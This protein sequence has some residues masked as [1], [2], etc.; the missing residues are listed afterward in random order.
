MK[1]V[2]ILL[3]F[4][5][6]A[7]LSFGQYS[8]GSTPKPYSTQSRCYYNKNSWSDTS[9][10]NSTNA[11]AVSGGVLNV[12]S[13]HSDALF[14]YWCSLKDTFCSDHWVMAYRI[15]M[16][17]TVGAST[18]GFSIGVKSIN[19]FSLCSVAGFPNTATGGGQT[20]FFTD[21]NSAGWT[22]YWTA[23]VGSKITIST[24][25]KIIARLE[26]SNQTLRLT[27]YNA[28]TKAAQFDTTVTLSYQATGSTPIMP[29]T[30]VPTF[31]SHGGNITIDSIYFQDEA[32]SN[33][34]VAIIGDSKIWGYGAT[35]Y[36]NT[37]PALLRNY[38][39]SVDVFAGFG[40]RTAEVISRLAEV[41]AVHPRCVIMAIGSNDVRNSVPTATLDSNLVKIDTTL[42]NAGI[43]V[44]W[45][46][47]FYETSVSLATLSSFINS[48]FA[49]RVINTY[50]P[51]QQSGCLYSDNIHLTN[52]GY[53]VAAR[54]IEGSSLIPQFVSAYRPNSKIDVR[55]ILKSFY[56]KNKIICIPNIFKSVMG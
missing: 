42:T 18:Y 20:Q 2:F 23:G 3:L 16:T 54:C 44:L 46:D 47:E 48:R 51:T 36:S 38:Y 15:A 13:A 10:F 14:N 35:A 31:W 55:E 9:D 45:T 56:D 11:V 29:N 24:S 30:G 7:V 6:S 39:N 27:I 34:D 22:T 17:S 53:D 25:N 41:K 28:T 50:L 49:G 43:Y 37:I 4:L 1:K 33:A 12:T 8:W 26:R 40:D 52:K 21:P 5:F 19:S 32:F